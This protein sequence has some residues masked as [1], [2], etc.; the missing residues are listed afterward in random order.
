MLNLM[1]IFS[2]SF[3]LVLVGLLLAP[4][5]LALAQPIRL[6]PLN[7][8]YFQF[9]NQPTV[10]IGSTE[11]YGLLLNRAFNYLTYFNTLQADE[12]NLTRVF[13]GVYCEPQGAFHIAQNTLAP[14]PGGLLCPW[15]RSGEP[16]YING[17][18]KFDLNHWDPI[19]FARLRQMME[20][21][22]ARNIVVELTLFCVYYEDISWR[23]SPLHPDNHIQFLGEIERQNVLSLQNS[24]YLQVQ[25]AMVEKIVRELNSFD[26]LIYEVV[27]E[28]YIRDTPEDWQHLVVQWITA[29][30]AALPKKHL[31][32]TNVANA[33]Q[34][35]DSVHPQVSILNF[36]YARPEAARHNYALNRVLGDDETGFNGQEDR[37]YRQEAWH[38][39][40]SGGGLFD[41]LDY[42]FAV[43]HEPGD[44]VYPPEQP[45]G[46][47]A[48]LRKQF[49]YLKN[50]LSTSPLLA[51]KPDSTLVTDIQA[52]HPFSWSALAEKDRHYLLYLSGEDPRPKKDYA[53][54]WQGNWVVPEEGLYQWRTYADDG[55][56]LWV[57]DTLL[58]DQWDRRGSGRDTAMLGLG[59]GDTATL[60]LEY[61]QGGGKA[62]LELNWQTPEGIFAFK[63]DD[64]WLGNGLTCQ[65]FS[66]KSLLNPLF[67]TR[68]QV[69][70]PQRIID[71]LFEKKEGINASLSLR[72]AEGNYQLEWM[73]PVLG[74]V[75]QRLSVNHKGGTL[76]LFPPPFYPDLA[77]RLTAIR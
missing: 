35:V 50:T 65:Y 58:I 6:H 3:A 45:G 19:Y 12:L 20:A 69:I 44:F 18:N 59:Q 40:L 38:F 63:P 30:E 51:M 67:E 57:N 16:G 39:M 34:R 76:K 10:L 64:I 77:L 22:A 5:F 31:I 66:G 53:M 25:Q 37:V 56:R 75:T 11:H 36:H 72:V 13:S 8:H 29:T 9:Q 42:S 55:L 48:T 73:D 49:R 24:A 28:P 1:P 2:R 32:A 27:N 7:P 14:E 15:A 23:Y 71:Q 43:G 62:F 54:R 74:R 4:G 68:I 52:D 60:R 21:A 17:G 47:S 26:N 61:Y 33:Y 46:G 41:H 70:S